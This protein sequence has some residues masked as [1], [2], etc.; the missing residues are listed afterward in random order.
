MLDRT[1]CDRSCS[2]FGRRGRYGRAARHR[3]LCEGRRRRCLGRSDRHGQGCRLRGQGRLR[4]GDRPRHATR[5][6]PRLCRGRARSC[7]CRPHRIDRPWSGRPAGR[8]Q[9]N[10]CLPEARRFLS[11]GKS[12]GPHRRIC[13]RSGRPGHRARRHGGG[14]RCGWCETGR[15]SGR[16]R[17]A[18]RGGGRHRRRRQAGDGRAAEREDRHRGI[19]PASRG[20][21][22]HHDRLQG[23]GGRQSSRPDR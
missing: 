5:G 3:E 18:R 9:G 11:A 14:A 16:D 23:R 19:G 20:R 13:R 17:Q 1:G 2:S 12:L 22:R 21:R 6:A 10:R 4:V 8:A 7:P 15:C